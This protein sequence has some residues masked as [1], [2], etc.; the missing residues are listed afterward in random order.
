MISGG[1]EMGRTQRG[2]DNSYC[3]DN[4]VSW[5]D[6]ELDDAHR[7]L[8]R[9]TRALIEL[10]K[11]HPLLQR[12]AFTA[13]PKGGVASSEVEWYR[14]DGAKMT[15]Q[16][17]ENPGTSSMGLYLSASGREVVDEEGRHLTDDD[18]FLVLNA[19]GVDLDFELPKVGRRGERLP[20]RLVVD[21]AVDEPRG[22]VAPGESTRMVARSLKVFSRPSLA[23]AGLDAAYGTPTST[24]RLQLR[25]GFGFA[26]AQRMADYLDSLGVGG[27][28]VS[29]ILRARPGS[30][31]GYDV[32]DHGALNPELGSADDFD[33][34]AA[35]LAR[36]ELRLLVDF[37]PNHVG[38]HGGSNAWWND[39]LEHGPSSVHADY[40]E[41]DWAPP[42][43]ALEGKVLLPVLGGQIGEEL[44]SGRIAV[45]RRGGAFVVTYGDAAFPAS[46]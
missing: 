9:F 35:E 23:P 4:D 7:A 11:S 8:L 28:Y 6:W 30:T 36:R 32:I 37:V 25:P 17:W 46:P 29:P 43:G 20:W 26:D 22:E 1:D 13:K 16:D 24:Y 10:R 15:S 39:V 45:A 33:A 40:F 18:L 42:T 31:H 2:N 14:H 12:G 19:S 21:T 5:Y 34:L 3:Q 41:I 27:V 44:E 38:V